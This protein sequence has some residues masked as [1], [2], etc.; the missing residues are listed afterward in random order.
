[1]AQAPSSLQ[2]DLTLEGESPLT[3]IDLYTMNLNYAFRYEVLLVVSV[4][5]MLSNSM[6]PYLVKNFPYKDNIHYVFI[7]S[8]K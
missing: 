6:S 5:I 1:M 4:C 8:N 2:G 3:P 7:L